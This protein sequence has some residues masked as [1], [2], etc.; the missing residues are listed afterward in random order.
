VAQT[1]NPIAFD[2]GVSLSDID[3]RVSFSPV[4][5]APDI[6]LITNESEELLEVK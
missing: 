2:G 5:T 4:A 6:D 1:D 3:S